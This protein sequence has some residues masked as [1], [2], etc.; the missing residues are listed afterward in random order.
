MAK[1][2]DEYQFENYES[3]VGGPDEVKH[4]IEHCPKCGSKLM[5]NHLPDYK[6]LLIQ[7]TGRC[8]ECDFGHRK[9]I[10]VLN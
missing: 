3:Y 6:N 10:H 4:E 1:E 7:E 5:F 2:R 9:T 8:L